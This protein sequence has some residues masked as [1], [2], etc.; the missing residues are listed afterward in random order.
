MTRK[1]RLWTKVIEDAGIAVRLYE[2]ASGS[3]IYREVRTGGGEKD[4]KSL[5][6]NDRALAETQAR[7][8]AQRISEL[9]FAGQS[10]PVRLGQL[11][12]LFERDRL[13]L[14]TATRQGAVRGMLLLLERH[15]GRGFD[16]DDLSQHHVDAYVAARTSGA[17]KSPRHRTPRV[18]ASA[19]TIRNE[20]HLLEAMV[21]WGQ[22]V[23]ISGKRL[24]T[25]N[26]IVGLVI[27]TEKN[28]KRPIATDA[29]FRALLAV[30]DVVEPTGRFRCVLSLARF[31]G[32]RIRAICELRRHDVLL[33]VADI[34]RALSA[35]GMD[36]AHAD[37]WS[38]GAI[39]W[40]STSDKLGFESITPISRECR[41]ALDT[42]L[43][44]RPSLGAAPLLAGIEDVAKPIKKEIASYWLRK[45]ERAAKVGHME[46]GGYHQFR[47]LWASERRH[48]PAQDV[49]A[50]GG[51]RSLEVMRSA[52]QQAD[53]QTVF[54]V[55]DLEPSGP[56]SDT[57][58]TEVKHA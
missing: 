7:V 36:L 28:A 43:R 33:T 56:T 27:P 5:G 39:V 25:G 18:G 26:P 52:Y 47:R 17:L 54:N 3:I 9:R 51:W 34:R 40:G 55:V 2:R 44:S 4:R 45:A 32:R 6:H 50:A 42:Y 38:H 58:R 15:F 8:L 16:V 13:P 21:R 23:R 41:S 12:A 48:L 10:G 22:G 14:M 24:I 31:T 57:P 29:R 53:A 46:R 11:A 1:K 20:L 49:A 19:G 35:A 37:H 30:A